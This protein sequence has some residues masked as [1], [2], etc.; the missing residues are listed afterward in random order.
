MNFTFFLE[1]CDCFSSSNEI[2]SIAN[3]LIN[4]RIRP[5]VQDEGGDVVFKVGFIAL[6]VNFFKL[7]LK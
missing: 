4:S 3:D 2:S 1:S 6:S 5:F 7:L